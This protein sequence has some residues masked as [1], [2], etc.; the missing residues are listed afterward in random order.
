MKKI[1]A[2][3]VAYAIFLIVGH[4]LAWILKED[5][6]QVMLHMLIATV[7]ALSAN[8]GEIKKGRQ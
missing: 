1:L 3:M 8:V 6:N 2:I 7:A 4:T 5:A